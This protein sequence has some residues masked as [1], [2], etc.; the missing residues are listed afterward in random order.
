M[1]EAARELSGRGPQRVAV[2][3]GADGV[4]LSEPAG[5][6]LAKP[7]RLRAVSA[8]GAGDALCAGLIDAYRRGLPPAD[9]LRRA[10]AV[11]A[12]SVL[13]QEAGTLN[14]QQARDLAG[15]VAIEKL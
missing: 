3:M 15:Q 4:L 7:P 9:A 5:Q 6:W 14:S 11:A 13:T 8:V 2:S 1:A 10:T 12:A